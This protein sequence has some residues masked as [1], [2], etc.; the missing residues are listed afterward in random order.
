MN[1]SSSSAALTFTSP[2]SG[3]AD[4]TDI[5]VSKDGTNAADFTVSALSS[6]SVA[7]GADSAT[8]AVIFTP[9]AGGTRTAGIHMEGSRHL[10]HTVNAG[11]FTIFPPASADSWAQRPTQVQLADCFG[12]R[13]RVAVLD[14]RA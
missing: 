8:F 10:H 13:E 3:T 12:V 9:G 2:T 5:A 11:S 4:L 1:V 6:T 14:Q 7:V